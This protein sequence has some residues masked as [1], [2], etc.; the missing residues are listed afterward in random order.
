MRALKPE[1][2]WK[3]DTMFALQARLELLAGMA[4][5]L[6]ALPGVFDTDDMRTVFA[7]LERFVKNPWSHAD[8]HA[9]YGG[10]HPCWIR[11]DVKG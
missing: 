2:V 10:R 11:D 4:A 3:L 7:W 6:A 8:T 1:Q 9:V 5:L